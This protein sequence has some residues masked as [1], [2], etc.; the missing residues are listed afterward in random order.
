MWGSNCMS[1]NSHDLFLPSG[2][3]V[4]FCEYTVCMLN[5]SDIILVKSLDICVTVLKD[6]PTSTYLDFS[7]P[8]WYPQDILNV[9]KVGIL[10][11][12]EILE[13][14][15]E[16][17]R[18]FRPE[19]QELGLL[20]PVMPLKNNSSLLQKTTQF[21][22]FQYSLKHLDLFKK[23]INTLNHSPFLHQDQLKCL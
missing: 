4:Y 19:C 17:L 16:I 10:R 22:T 3:Q 12:L 14:K 20:L 18:Q 1:C 5:I 21:E 11:G 6:S 9:F 13:A 15:V 7:P 23:K 8:L 2:I